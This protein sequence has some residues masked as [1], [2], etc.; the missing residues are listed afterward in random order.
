MLNKYEKG[1]I[2]KITDLGYNKMYIGST[3][4]ILSKRMARHRAGYNYKRKNEK[5]N[6]ASV[7]LFDEFGIDNC[8]I[9]LVENYPCSSKEE[10]FKR[11]G[12]YIQSNDC[13]NKLIMGR[14]KK[15]WYEDNKEYV[16][17]NTKQ[18][19]IENENHYKQTNRKY[20]DNNKEKF[21]EKKKEHYKNNKQAYS[22]YAKSY[23]QRNKE[24]I[25]QQR[26]ERYYKQ[27]EN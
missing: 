11:E 18:W 17:K 4:E 16:Y 25:K 14:T 2:Y 26:M 20:Y 9:E 27:K 10:L 5:K 21:S 23:Y 6:C 13:L 12:F 15:D 3:C 22:D 19:R 8:K 1:K 7:R 24:K